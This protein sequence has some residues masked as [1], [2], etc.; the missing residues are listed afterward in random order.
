[1]LVAGQRSVHGHKET[2]VPRVKEQH[3]LLEPTPLPVD[4]IPFDIIRHS[5]RYR[6]QNSD[7][8]CYNDTRYVLFLLD[9]SGSIGPH[10][11]GNMTSSLSTLVHYFCRWIKV[12]A[13]TFSD[14]H[15]IEFCFDCF[16]DDC[17]G[18]D[19]ARDAMHN[20]RYRGGWTHTGLATQCACDDVLSP[21]CGFPDVTELSEPDPI[22]LD[23]IYVTDGQS[24]GDTKVC[25]KVQCLYNLRSLGVNLTVYAFGVDDY[26]E[27][28]LKC[29]SRPRIADPI[30]NPIFK[31]DSFEDLANKIN[32][33]EEVFSKMESSPDS[34]TY[35]FKYSSTMHNC[36]TSY[37]SSQNGTE[38][39]TNDCSIPQ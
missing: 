19:N 30:L 17:R 4:P 21:I 34:G 5:T 18:R 15:F 36:F 31:V 28:E 22:C 9:T 39:D 10:D 25:Q 11:F 24:N 8:N 1:M 26:N 20:I 14:E 35:K 27:D 32:E 33:I 2:K 7:V 37:R 3:L 23:V 6:R 29:I 38:T 13:M 16:D 12:A